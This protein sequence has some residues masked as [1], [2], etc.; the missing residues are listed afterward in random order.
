[1]ANYQYS[2][3]YSHTPE[4]LYGQQK[5][6]D[7]QGL[8]P[9]FSNDPNGP[10][11]SPKWLCGKDSA[12]KYIPR[13]LKV[14]HALDKGSFAIAWVIERDDLR[15][16]KPVEFVA[17]VVNK[18][19][20]PSMVRRRTDKE[21]K[22][23]EELTIKEVR[24]LADLRHKH[25]MFD[26]VAFL[27]SKNI[28]HRDIKL[29]N[30]LIKDRLLLSDFGFAAYSEKKLGQKKCGSPNF[31]APELF[32]LCPKDMYYGD[33]VD[34]WS[35]GANAYLLLTGNYIYGNDKELVFYTANTIT[36]DNIKWQLEQNFVTKR[37]QEVLLNCLNI[38]PIKRRSVPAKDLL[39]HK[40][41]KCCDDKHLDHNAMKKWKAGLIA[42]RALNSVAE[43]LYEKKISGNI[44]NPPT[45]ISNQ[46]KLDQKQDQLPLRLKN[47][48]TSKP[49][50]SRSR[51]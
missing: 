22:E 40:W 31:A 17:K 50:H 23:A 3:V 32:R 46:K 39:G 33:S 11:F 36:N 16:D 29:Q 9:L 14:K 2:S 44:H 12:G 21:I 38:D 19:R 25:V 4:T 35:L 34:I 15:E 30:F 1:M 42:L 45:S 27:H 28:M 24:L 51:G 18:R 20:G 37:A 7:L 47:T 49:N 13:T 6:N 26:A 41:F 8:R 48:E 43:N 5:S 10:K